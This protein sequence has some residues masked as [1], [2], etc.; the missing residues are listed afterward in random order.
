MT[1]LKR[2]RPFL[3]SWPWP[4]A[5]LKTQVSVHTRAMYQELCLNPSGSDM[6]SG[7]AELGSTRSTLLCKAI[8]LMV[9]LPSSSRYHEPCQV[10]MHTSSDTFI[11]FAFYAR[12]VRATPLLLSSF[13]FAPAGTS[14]GQ[15]WHPRTGPRLIPAWRGRLFLECGMWCGCYNCNIS[16]LYY[17]L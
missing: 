2:E 15:R 3:S 11:A 6:P 4:G 17:V 8:I 9:H 12:D 5:Q 10:S 7:K 14:S 16:I 1:S 13:K